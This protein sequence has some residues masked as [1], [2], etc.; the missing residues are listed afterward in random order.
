MGLGQWPLYF[1][2]A[3][4]PPN[5]WQSLNKPACVHIHFVLHERLQIWDYGEAWS[6]EE[7]ELTSCRNL[8]LKLCEGRCVKGTSSLE[9]MHTALNKPA[10]PHWE[11]AFLWRMEETESFDILSHPHKILHSE[12]KHFFPFFAKNILLQ[13]IFTSM[14]L[15]LKR[16]QLLGFKVVS[17]HFGLSKEN[18]S[19]SS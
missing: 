17:Q 5:I 16:K 9:H 10:V 8:S 18:N 1:V 15:T 14:C 13:L 12:I 7:R 6:K 2:G 3:R 4:D 19:K 11:K